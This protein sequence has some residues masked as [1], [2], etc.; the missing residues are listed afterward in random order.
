M[1][2]V[3]I[4]VMFVF[5]DW[6]DKGDFTKSVYETRTGVELSMS[7]FH[8]GSSFKGVIE[9]DEEEAK[10]LLGAMKDGFRPVFI[11]I[12]PNGKTWRWS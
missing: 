6:R 5:D 1:R 11:A 2:K 12:D 10:F 4:K 8:H 7:S 9:V 3:R